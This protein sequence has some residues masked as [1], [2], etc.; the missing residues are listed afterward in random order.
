M[1]NLYTN[2]NNHSVEFKKIYMICIIKNIK[3]DFQYYILILLKY[4][5]IR[6]SYIM[7]PIFK[8]N[9]RVILYNS[10]YNINNNTLNKKE[11]LKNLHFKINT[12][13]A[14]T[15]WSVCVWYIRKTPPFYITTYIGK[16]T[17]IIYLSVLM[18]NIKH[19]LSFSKNL[20]F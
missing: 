13:H 1:Y 9:T 20:A 10:R 17:H 4:I 12:P 2:I 8:I 16:S 15:W 7:P 14:Q 6:S 19:V 11:S 18:I 5:K 3:I